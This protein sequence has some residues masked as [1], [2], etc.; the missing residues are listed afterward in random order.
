MSSIKYLFFIF[1]LLVFF[2]KF[3]GKIHFQYLLTAFNEFKNYP[4]KEIFYTL[5]NLLRRINAMALFFCMVL[6]YYTSNIFY[7]YN[8]LRIY[9]FVV[10]FKNLFQIEVIRNNNLWKDNYEMFGIFFL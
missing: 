4:W 1:G 2:L 10:L 7:N 5:V 3:Y 9:T 8:L 6:S